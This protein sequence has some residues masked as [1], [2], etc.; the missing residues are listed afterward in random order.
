MSTDRE[1]EDRRRLQFV[2]GEL[3]KYKATVK[4]LAMELERMRY[5]PVADEQAIRKYALEQA[6]DH[7]MDH[8]IIRGGAELEQVCEQIKRLQPAASFVKARKR[9]DISRDAWV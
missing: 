6:A 5:E 2:E 1:Q 4:R 9:Y 3:E 7:L 8:G